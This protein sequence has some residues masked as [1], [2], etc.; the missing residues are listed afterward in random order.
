MYW[1]D[2]RCCEMEVGTV[3]DR[4]MDSEERVVVSLEGRR[5]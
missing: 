4:R 3:A 2:L 5:Y 1:K